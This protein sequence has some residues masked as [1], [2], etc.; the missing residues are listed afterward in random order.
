M[1]WSGRGALTGSKTEG[2]V[3]RTAFWARYDEALP[4]I[5]GYLVRRSGRSVA[6]DL[7]QEVFSTMARTM[8][9]GDGTTVTLPWLLT[10]ARS[11]LFD[12]LRVQQRTLRNTQ[13]ASNWSL[14][15]PTVTVEASFDARNLGEAT[16]DAL[17]ALSPS[18]RAVLVL[19]HLDDLTVVEVADQ[20]GRSVAATESL[21][22]GSTKFPRGVSGGDRCLSI[23]S[24]IC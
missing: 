13:L 24:A 10:V 17:D 22:K 15:A 14:T 9:T 7:T 20:L 8:A 23:R 18:Q 4:K 5:Y 11:R 21:R 6:E 3:D 19:H 2:E 12:H 16:A 1:Y